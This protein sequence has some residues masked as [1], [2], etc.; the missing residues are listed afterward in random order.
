MIRLA[1]PS[2]TGTAAVL[3]AGAVNNPADV[4]FQGRIR[5]EAD[6]VTVAPSLPMYSSGPLGDQIRFLRDEFTPAVRVV[7]VGGVGAPAEP[8][9][10]F[11][12]PGEI[13]VATRQVQ[14]VVE[15]KNV[16]SNATVKVWLRSASSGGTH[17]FVNATFQSGTT[18]QSTWI[19]TGDL[20]A[21]AGY[22]TVQ[23][24]VVLP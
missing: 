22:S 3:G 17:S 23:A 5:I 16:P 14:V 19:A 13:V 2:V 11:E 12:L 20:G 1:A 18:E 15:C 6:T 4:R 24:H 8:R 10:Q 9:A 7:S 21:P